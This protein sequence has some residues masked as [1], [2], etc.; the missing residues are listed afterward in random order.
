MHKLWVCILVTGCAMSHEVSVGQEIEL[1]PVGLYTDPNPHGAVPKGAL[2]TAKNVVLR[3]DGLLEPRPGFERSSASLTGTDPSQLIPYD[4]DLLIVEKNG[5]TEKTDWYNAGTPTNV[6]DDDSA[7]LDWDMD[8]I[9]A[10]E[11]RGNLYIATQ[12]SVRKLTSKSDTAAKK[13]GAPIPLS[14]SLNTAGAGVV[15]DQY[16]GRAYRAVIR[17][18]DANNVIVRSP[19]SAASIV[20]HGGATSQKVDVV[21][22]FDSAEVEGTATAG[23]PKDVLEIYRTPQVVGSASANG[24]PGEEYFLIDEHE[25]TAAEAAAG[26]YTFADNKAD[27]LAGAALYTNPSQEGILQNNDYMHVAKDLVEFKN[28]LFAANTRGPHRFSFT[29]LASYVDQTGNAAGI[30]YRTVLTGNTTS[31]D[32]DITGVSAGDRVG[33]KVGMI[34]SGTGIPNKARISSIS[35]SPPHTIT[36]TVNA[37]ATGNP[38]LTFD[39]VIRVKVGALE[40]FYYSVAQIDGWAQFIENVNRNAWVGSDGPSTYVYARFLSRPTYSVSYNAPVEST[41]IIEERIRDGNAFEVWHTYSN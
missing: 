11:S 13:A 37:T 24:I 41:L 40:D 15:L 14:I 3:R 25:L 38:T 35:G 22:D 20:D 28:S 6:K 36:M 7:D 21:V 18:T 26:T 2:K 9:G 19:V 27:A 32:P 34:I 17:R 10:A 16:G 8:H 12:D 5:G 1:R 39:D 30:G 29:Q 4:G 31:S 33:L 23:T